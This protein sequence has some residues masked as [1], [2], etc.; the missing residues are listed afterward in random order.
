MNF[1]YFSHSVTRKTKVCKKGTQFRD[2]VKVKK[3]LRTNQRRVRSRDT[4]NCRKLSTTTRLERERET[5]VLPKVAQT[6]ARS[7]MF[8]GPIP[9]DL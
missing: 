2:L 1:H 4:N 8:G 7:W 6:L 5:M 3:E 9:W